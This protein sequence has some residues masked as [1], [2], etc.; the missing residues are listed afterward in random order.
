MANMLYHA[1]APFTWGQALIHSST[2]L[3]L[4]TAPLPPLALVGDDLTA[5]D[6]GTNH[7]VADTC[8]AFRE[9]D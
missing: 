3:R 2:S 1:S 8:V 4:T 5:H 7:A 9:S 6:G